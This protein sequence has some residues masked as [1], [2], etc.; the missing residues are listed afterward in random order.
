[1]ARTQKTESELLAMLNAELRYLPECVGAEITRL[2]LVKR[3]PGLS[4]WDVDFRAQNTPITG[5]CKHAILTAKFNLQRQ[6]DLD[7][8]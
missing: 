1:M 6:Y 5:M 8:D 3:V 7:E 4:N 2:T